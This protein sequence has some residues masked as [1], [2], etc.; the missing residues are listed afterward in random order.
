MDER[1]SFA[2]VF[3]VIRIL[4]II[5]GAYIAYNQIPFLSRCEKASG[6]AIDLLWETVTDE[7]GTH[8]YCYPIVEFI[9]TRGAGGVILA[10]G[11]GAVIPQIMRSRTSWTYSTTNRNQNTSTEM[12]SGIFG[13][14]PP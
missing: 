8:Q 12:I 1:R 14:A 4:A 9:N 2:A 6:T 5:G 13:W 10:Q 7:D 11:R 3:V